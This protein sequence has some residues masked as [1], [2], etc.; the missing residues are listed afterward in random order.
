[1]QR[2]DRIDKRT[3]VCDSSRILRRCNYV[4]RYV[5]N[6]HYVRKDISNYTENDFV[7]FPTY[8]GKHNLKA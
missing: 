7:Y 5:I 8:N 1:M 2:Q 4:C 6:A 3:V